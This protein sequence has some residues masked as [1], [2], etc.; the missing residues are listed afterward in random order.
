LLSRADRWARS[1]FCSA[2]GDGRRAGDPDPADHAALS[3][4]AIEDAW[5]EYEEQLRSLG[6]GD[7]CGADAALGYAFSLLTT[8]LAGFGRRG[9]KSAR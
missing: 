2:L 6:A 9:P 3:R 7:E 1:E 5:R 8:I 4:Q